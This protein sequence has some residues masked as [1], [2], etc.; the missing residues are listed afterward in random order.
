MKGKKKRRIYEERNKA[1]FLWIR[2]KGG[3]DKT[4]KAVSANE[5][6]LSGV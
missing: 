1:G 4:W 2:G 3:K 6:R 5:E